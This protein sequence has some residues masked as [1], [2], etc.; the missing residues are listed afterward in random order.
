MKPRKTWVILGLAGA[1]AAL[2]VA[3]TALAQTPTPTPGQQAKSNY[4]EFFLD[5]L[6]AALGTTRDKLNSAFTQARNE[7]AD[8]MV[9]DGKLTQQQADK[10]KAQQG[11]GPL[12]FGFRGIDR[13]PRMKDGAFFLGGAQVQ[14]AIAKALGITREEL[15]N[16]LR[17]GKTLAEL[18]KGKEQAV[19]DAVVEAMKSQ[20]DQAVK[21]GRLTQEQADQMLEKIR[22]TD[23]STLGVWGKGWF[24]G[25]IQ[26]QAPSTK[27]SMGPAV[28]ARAL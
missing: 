4:H 28:G 11:T 15:V 13:A 12:G 3:G 17:S 21:N 25:G 20:L 6:A 27:P 22:N 5:R 7:T 14:E 8:Q 1:V 23:L 19:K 26:K 18:I 10:L 24:R 16:Q 9:K 2:V